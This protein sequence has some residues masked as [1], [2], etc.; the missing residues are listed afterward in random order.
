MS[1]L[2]DNFKDKYNLINGVDFKFHPNVDHSGSKNRHHDLLFKESGLQ[3]IRAI[4]ERRKGL[5]N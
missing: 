2:I 1:I 4:R 3:K 5:K